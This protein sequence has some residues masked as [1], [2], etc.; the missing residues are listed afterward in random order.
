M[1]GEQARVLVFPQTL[2]RS[3]RGTQNRNGQ[4]HGD[5]TDQVE[6][7]THGRSSPPSRT[8]VRRS[9]WRF[10]KKHRWRGQ[11]A[12]LRRTPRKR[13]KPQGPT[14]LQPHSHTEWH[15]KQRG[16]SRWKDREGPHMCV[17]YRTLINTR[18]QRVGPQPSLDAPPAQRHT[19]GHQHT[20][21]ARTWGIAACTAGIC[22][23]SIPRPRN[24]LA[25]TEH[26]LG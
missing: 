4:R 13:R 24:P 17:S 11:I 16:E 18:T 10:L 8:R 21:D 15:D 25:R 20:K 7:V 22:G 9:A 5:S 19:A 3:A 2:H 12:T 1:C 23:Q 26:P 14:R 6:A